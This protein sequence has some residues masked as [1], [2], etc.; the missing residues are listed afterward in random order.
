MRILLS[1]TRIGTDQ[2]SYAYRLFVPFT[3]ISLERQALIS[4]RSDYG[5]SIGLLARLPEVIAPM[6]Y[7]E[8][9]PGL[10]KYHEG[11][12]L[13]LLASRVAAILL[14]AAFPEMFENT[15]PFRL[16]VPIALPN[17]RLFADV[18]TLSGRAAWLAARIDTLSADMLGFHLEG[19]Q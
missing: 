10:D 8:A 18:M 16:M 2:P 3:E 12:A 5:Y 13:D 7:L 6:A 4:M 19:E 17:T 15:V 14:R 1:R 9:P 11:E